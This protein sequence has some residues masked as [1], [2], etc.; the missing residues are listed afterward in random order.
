MRRRAVLATIFA[1]LLA[2]AASA[3][4]PSRPAAPAD[5]A[6]LGRRLAAIERDLERWVAEWSRDEDWF[7][8]RVYSGNGPEQWA[9]PARKVRAKDLCEIVVE[10]QNEPALRLAAADALK[11][12]RDLDPDLALEKGAR[13][14]RN[15]LA[16]RHLVRHVDAKDAVTR[17]LVHE[18]LMA[19]VPPSPVPPEIRSYDSEGG[20]PA[21][22]RAAERAWRVALAR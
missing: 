6:D 13:K 1:A 18:L 2:G 14:P 15:E 21:S 8:V 9:D 11:R 10:T 16:L 4:E 12:A 20:T 17:S 19:L 5:L 22:F 3:G 7:A